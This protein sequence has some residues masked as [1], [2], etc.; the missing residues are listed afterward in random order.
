[1][2][3]ARVLRHFLTESVVLAACAGA[4]GLLIAELGIR[5]LVNAGPS[6]LP[7][8]AEVRVDGWV[9]LFTLSV[10]ALVAVACSAIPAMRVARAELASILREGGRGGTSGRARHRVRGALVAAQIA[11]A[12]VVLAGSGLLLRSF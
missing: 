10:T 1:A 6:E 4:L 9:V 3:R 7:R 11:L 12:V 8:L 5:A 2:G